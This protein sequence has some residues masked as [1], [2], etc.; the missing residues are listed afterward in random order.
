MVRVN[1]KE[2]EKHKLGFSENDNLFFSIELSGSGY[3]FYGFSKG[4]KVWIDWEYAKIDEKY[5]NFKTFFCFNDKNAGLYSLINSDI[6][7][8]DLLDEVKIEELRNQIKK[9]Y[10]EKRKN[11]IHP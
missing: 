9:Y 4:D 10:E 2:K 7:D 8:S 6:G 1:L 11:A 5:I 3:L